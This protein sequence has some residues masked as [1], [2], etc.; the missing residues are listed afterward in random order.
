MK[1]VLIGILVAIWLTRCNGIVRKEFSRK[2]T[3]FYVGINYY[4]SGKM[5]QDFWNRYDKSEIE[6][7]FRVMKSLDI[8]PVRVFLHQAN[9]EEAKTRGKAI[10]NLEHLIAT[11]EKFDN[12]LIITA[13]DWARPYTEEIDVAKPS[14][15]FNVGL[16][17]LI[18]K[19][20]T[21][22]G[23]FAWDIKNE[24][25]H[26]FKYDGKEVVLSWLSGATAV[27]NGRFPGADTTIGWLHL[28]PE[29]AVN[30]KLT[31][32]SFHH[33]PEQGDLARRIEEFRKF[34]P[35][36]D[37][38]LEEIGYSTGSAESEAQTMTAE[39]NQMKFISEGVFTSLRYNLAGMLIWN[40]H[41]HHKDEG[42]KRPPHENGFGIFRVDGSP[43][44]IASIL[45]SGIYPNNCGHQEEMGK[46]Q[47]FCA[48]A[49]GNRSQVQT[50]FSGPAGIEFKA[51]RFDLDAGIHCFCYNSFQAKILA[52]GGFSINVHHAGLTTI[53]GKNSLAPGN[54]SSESM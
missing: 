44:P 54:W 8:R 33:F 35:R 46:V 17:D 40:L 41:D 22:R 28:L 1:H 53:N 29:V 27:I 13:F 34:Y 20:H 6:N 11:A 25:D 51:D 16:L 10:D 47:G 30:E 50:Y 21:R 36:K 4:P 24:P 23:I 12:R 43:K 19:N 37:L 7:D 31:F 5:W 26:D 3:E 42:P 15:R 38:V 45:A 2:F 18:K 49:S 14:A 48:S 9:F 32:L 39:K 52:W